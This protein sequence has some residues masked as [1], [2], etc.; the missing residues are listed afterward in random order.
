MIL[1]VTI[2]G[3]ECKRDTIW[4]EII[5]SGED[6]YEDSKVRPNKYYL[7]KWGKGIE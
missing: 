2:M 4:G 3:H 5:R 7:K 6:I 1:V